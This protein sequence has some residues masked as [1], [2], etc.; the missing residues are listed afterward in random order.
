VKFVCPK[1]ATKEQIIGD[2]TPHC[3][4]CQ[5]RML[6]AMP[7]YTGLMMSPSF[8]I[9]RFETVINTRGF[10][11]AKKGGAKRERE[12]WISAVWA[13]GL[14]ETTGREY[15]IEIVTDDQTPDTKVHFLDQS[16][17]H[18]HR[19]THNLEIVEWDEHRSDVMD[20]IAQKCRK[21]YP[22]YFHLVVLARNG[23]NIDVPSL[24]EQIKSLSVPF[25]EMW[26]LGRISGY[27]Y[28]MF[29]FYPGQQLIEF[30]LRQVLA[31]NSNKVDFLQPLGRGKST[32]FEDLGVG[33]L[34]IP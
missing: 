7:G 26:I 5:V 11:E 1:C 12:A 27:A 4:I 23:K 32:E 3:R 34:P 21:A 30:D 28:K 33:Y 14:R 9:R 6:K 25:A 31:G 24:L 20:V 8:V 16:A 15:W 2:E 18:N 13:L 22:S 17:G 29:M 10:A 19:M